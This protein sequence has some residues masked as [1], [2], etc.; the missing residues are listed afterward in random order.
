M[1]GQPWIKDG[2]LV[3]P[4]TLNELQKAK[5]HAQS[6]LHMYAVYLGELDREIE[7][8]MQRKKQ[9]LTQRLKELERRVKELEAAAS[10]DAM[11]IDLGLECE[12]NLW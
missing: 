7:L 3:V 12:G 9:D 8:Q 5:A 4:K 10:I 1:A 6:H 11:E 2:K